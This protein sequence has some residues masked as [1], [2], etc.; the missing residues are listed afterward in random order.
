MS[1]YYD[2][3]PV[4]RW[5]E[6]RPTF[7]V[8]WWVVLTVVGVVFVGFMLFAGSNV[9]RG[10]GRADYGCAAVVASPTT[11]AAD[12]G[13]EHRATVCAQQ[14]SRR[15]AFAGIATAVTVGCAILSRRAMRAPRRRV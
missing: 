13:F 14:R 10:E 11:V 1:N 12:E 2:K 7:A 4:E 8:V 15:L 3:Y 5:P 9:D 6:G